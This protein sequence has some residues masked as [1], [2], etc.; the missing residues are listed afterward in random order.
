V[1]PPEDIGLY[2][3]ELGM[4]GNPSVFISYTWESD[5]HRVWVL[6]LAEQL[7]HDGVNVRIDQWYMR[8]G[9]EIPSF[10]ETAVRES[11]FVIMVCTPRFKTA[12][13]DRIGG[14][15]YENQVLTGE[16]LALAHGQKVIPVLRTG[17]WVES[18]PSWVLGRWYVDMRG[19]GIDAEGYSLLSRAL[20]GR[21]A[22]ADVTTAVST[23]VD[24]GQ[25]G[26]RPVIIAHFVDHYV[27]ELSGYGFTGPVFARRV[28][29]EANLALRIALL[30]ADQVLVPAVS[31]FQSPLCRRIVTK[32]RSVFDLGVIKL[33]GDAYDWREFREN[34]LR[35]Y[36]P[37][38]RQFDIYDGIR[39]MRWPL[40]GLAGADRNTTDA[41]HDE[42]R[43]FASPTGSDPLRAADLGRSLAGM[44][45]APVNLNITD[46]L[47]ILGPAAF[48]GE[49]V[50]PVLFSR[51]DP[52]L[53]GRLSALI[54]S[55]FFRV[56][57][58]DH[59]A[60]LMEDL[61]YIRSMKP[62]AGTTVLSYRS[63]VR[64][65]RLDDELWREV[66]RCEPLDL[67]RLQLDPRIQS[68]TRNSFR[69]ND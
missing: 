9:D 56:M 26:R 29:T 11:D 3:R 59:R 48:V 49:N 12:S 51:T 20:F 6:S 17:E 39:R 46:V 31:F 50:Y 34:R 16:V 42:W 62:A 55:M 52:A 64:G 15:G 22:G 66:C 28:A 61:T 18:A 14:V 1:T 8:P 41:L 32:F 19:P 58:A 38:S 45:A 57:S 2:D 7:R 36:A 47:D 23:V 5:E 25:P 65:L 4:L 13:D 30:A 35:E 21:F 37:G 40:P 27:L 67:L 53:L 68:I 54:C 33:V 24:V 69:P 44:A 10:M 60:T 63:Y 43:G